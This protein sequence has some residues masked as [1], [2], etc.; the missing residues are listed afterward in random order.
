MAFQ[1]ELVKVSHVICQ[2]DVAFLGLREFDT[3]IFVEH[4]VAVYSLN[5]QI[6]TFLRATSSEGTLF[7]AILQR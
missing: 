7:V 4:E 5:T 2:L 1:D 6:L 3:V